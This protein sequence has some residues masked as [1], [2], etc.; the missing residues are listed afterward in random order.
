MNPL[1]LLLIQPASALLP[2]CPRLAPRT[3][4]RATSQGRSSSIGEYD[5]LSGKRI[6]RWN[7]NGPLR[8]PFGLTGNA[9]IWNGRVA[10]LVFVVVLLEELTVFPEGVVTP[11]FSQP[12]SENVALLASY[13]IGLVGSVALGWLV[14]AK[15]AAG[16]SSALEEA[17]RDFDL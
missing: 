16:R 14:W 2:A 13:G 1:A 17:R 5:P 12:A 7:D 8:S 6:F 9:E 10:Q 4:L 11:L 15:S 3:H